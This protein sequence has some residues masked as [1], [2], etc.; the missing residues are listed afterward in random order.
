MEKPMKFSEEDSNR[1]RI[2]IGI[3]IGF[4]GAWWF[5]GPAFALM[6]AGF[7]Y[8]VGQVAKYVARL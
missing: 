2:T 6:V 7:A 1:L 4:G 5:A 3:A 8:Y